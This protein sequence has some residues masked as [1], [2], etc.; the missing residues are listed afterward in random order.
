M[1]K[2]F[3]QIKIT[4]MEAN[5]KH[6]T[7]SAKEFPSAVD[8]AQEL[9][10]SKPELFK[11]NY[12]TLEAIA[13][14]ILRHQQKY[15]AFKPPLSLSNTLSQSLNDHFA[16]IAKMDAQLNYDINIGEPA[17]DN[18]VREK[19]DDESLHQLYDYE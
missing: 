1:N 14:A 15:E 18:D 4:Q 8:A 6:S 19:L 17:S 16:R 3:T 2:N 7:Q 12:A 5:L 9:I 11:N 10:Q 13:D